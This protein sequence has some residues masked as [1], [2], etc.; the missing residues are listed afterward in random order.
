MNY[1]PIFVMVTSVAVVIQAGVLIGMFFTLRKTADQLQ[2][3][4][5]HVNTTILPAVDLTREMLVELR[6]Q[7]ENIATNLNSTSIIVRAQVERFDT[8]VT[9]LLDRARLQVIRTDELVGRA[10]DRVEA[11][12]QSVQRTVSIPVKQFSGIMRGVSAGLEY[13]ATKKRRE[14]AP[15]DEMFI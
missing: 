8:T 5:N 2:I 9:E 13:L 10:L 14:S 3:V 1:L 15:Q 6:P 7:I 11:T 12:S 4:T